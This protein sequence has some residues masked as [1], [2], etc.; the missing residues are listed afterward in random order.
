M[1]DIVEIADELLG[2]YESGIPVPRLTERFPG[3]G[4]DVAYRVQQHQ[5][6]LSL[7]HI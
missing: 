6:D 2:A 1:D 4:L 7:I 5:V 3:R